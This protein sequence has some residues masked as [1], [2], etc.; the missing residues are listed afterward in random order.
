MA[1]I[2]SLSVMLTLI[3]I[4][5]ITFFKV[6]APFILPLFLAGVAAL[7]CQP[8]YGKLVAR[9]NG[10]SR[11]AAGLMTTAVLLL[12][13]IPVVTL[14]TIASL[15]LF[16]SGSQM[17]VREVEKKATHAV[18]V[19]VTKAA[20]TLIDI[21]DRLP[22]GL[23]MRID[24]A[25]L[26]KA[27]QRGDLDV[28]DDVDLLP[29][30]NDPLLL[31]ATDGPGVEAEPLP[32]AGPDVD[33][34]TPDD[35]AL[36]RTVDGILADGAVPADPVVAFAELP[37][38]QRVALVESEIRHKGS[39]ALAD[40]GERSLGAA[41]KTLTGTLNVIQTGLGAALGAIL[42]LTM[43]GIGLYYFLADGPAMLRAV[44]EL[45]PVQTEYQQA[46]LGQ[47]SSVVRSVV[48]ATF[49]AALVQAIMCVVALGLCGIPHLVILFVVAL[50]ASM[51]PLAGTWLVWGPAA[52]YLFLEGRYVAG[53]L[54]VLWG[55]GV[56][57]VMDNVVRTYILGA[58]TKLHP[59]LAFVSVLGGLQVMG[60]W[61]IFVGPIVAS[62][63]HALIEIFN[64]ELGEL[65]RET[66]AGGDAAAIE[67][68][69]IGTTAPTVPDSPT[70]TA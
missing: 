56:I 40:I 22:E 6:V 16:S 20:T 61:G 23:R 24:P 44:Q 13:L 21:Q 69:K 65:S 30:E 38:E 41:G 66:F 1:R 19:L 4:L 60:L 12:I 3:V 49:L 42:G 63:L 51:I 15:H 27:R 9:C 64:Q 7:L 25:T 57:G 52:L 29:N 68:A 10:R 17:Q 8:S 35:E 32:D 43:F 34:T 11:V 26:V 54:L 36:Q 18:D 45:I 31:E 2:V 67:A 50:V 53:T 28:I 70:E 33:A 58:Q 62:C 48:I 47:F 39:L 37:Y 5:G 14:I 55:G 59:L 46:L